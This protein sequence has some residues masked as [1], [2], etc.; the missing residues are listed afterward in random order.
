MG[1]AIGNELSGGF[2]SDISED[3]K[4][5]AV[6]VA[7]NSLDG[8]FPSEINNI[9]G[10]QI[11]NIESNGFSGK[12]PASLYTLPLTELSI[13]GNEFTG[14]IP[15]NLPEVANLTSISLGPNK[16]TGDIPTNLSELT[17]LKRLSIVGIPDLNGRL[18]ASYGLNLT[19][20]VELSIADT[21]VGGDIPYQY[22]EM[23]NLETL[24]LSN[25]N[26]RGRILPQ[27]GLMTNLSKYSAFQD[28]RVCDVNSFD[29]LI[30]ICFFSLRRESFSR[31][32]CFNRNDTISTGIVNFDP[33]ASTT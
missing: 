6:N 12:L 19:D 21:N 11:L 2:P 3:T 1:L 10:L 23:T 31:W 7:S 25:N 14:T 26:I 15:G 13:G 28:Y 33:R 30:E 4:L 16:F 8:S 29:I 5:F 27:F 32:K 17:A 9:A 24:R 18:P 22:T 20:L